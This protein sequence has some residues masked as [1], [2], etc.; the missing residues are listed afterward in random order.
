MGTLSFISD[1]LGVERL[2]I[3]E[4]ECV[5]LMSLFLSAMVNIV[6]KRG[7]AGWVESCFYKVT[8][9][10]GGQQTEL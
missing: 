9:E 2:M 7:G 4:A 3:L 1:R 8:A 6:K 10:G 5:I